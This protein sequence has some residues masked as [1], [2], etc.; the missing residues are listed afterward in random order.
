M[1]KEEKKA[2]KKEVNKM[3]I[4]MLIVIVAAVSGVYY[5]CTHYD[6]NKIFGKAGVEVNDS[7]IS[8]YELDSLSNIALD[9]VKTDSVQVKSVKKDT[10]I[11]VKK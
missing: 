6:L 9:S 11:V 8:N 2:E 4:T 1:E 5:A 10:T 7:A 3:L